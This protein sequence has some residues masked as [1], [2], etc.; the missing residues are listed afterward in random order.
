MS[1]CSGD[2]IFWLISMWPWSDEEIQAFL[3]TNWRNLQILK[4]I[5]REIAATGF[6]K[7]AVQ[8]EYNRNKLK[9]EYKILRDDYHACLR[10][11]LSSQLAIL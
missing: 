2:E 9:K 5:A 11:Y 10:N 1:S 6:C 7:T 3:N 4:R 8:C